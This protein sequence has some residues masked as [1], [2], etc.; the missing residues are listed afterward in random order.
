MDWRVELSDIEGEQ[1]EVTAIQTTH[2]PEVTLIEGENLVCLVSLG[3]DNKR[4]VGES[5]LE[6]LVGSHH[7]DRCQ[8]V[9]CCEGTQFRT[10]VRRVEPGRDWRRCRRAALSR[11]SRVRTTPEE[12]RSS[13]QPR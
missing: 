12:A 3:K 9:G 11:G 13:G 2:C 10:R 5:D 1:F 6:V 4:G 8:Q 7:V